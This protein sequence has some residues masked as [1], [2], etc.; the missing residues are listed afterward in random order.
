MAFT[1]PVSIRA[2]VNPGSNQASLLQF[3]PVAMRTR[4][5]NDTAKCV[6]RRF[7]RFRRRPV[8]Y[9]IA[10]GVLSIGVAA[11]TPPAYAQD[12]F[13]GFIV[14]LRDVCS[15]KPA[16]VCTQRVAAFLDSDNDSRISLEEFQSVHAQAKLA[17][18]RRGSSLS[19]TEH[20]LISIGLLALPRAN[21]AAIFARFDADADGGLSEDEL[22]SDFALDRRPLGKIIADPGGVDWKS[23]AA[24]FG[25]IGFLVLDLLPP[26]RREPS[27]RE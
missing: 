2:S 5:M 17:L 3:V 13:A 18:K 11:A 12:T 24:R 23:F 4:R 14:G 15:Q 27:R 25:K 19:A 7:R 26:G 1:P 9:L 6:F 10:A 8:G 16:R 20:N 22:F 21:L